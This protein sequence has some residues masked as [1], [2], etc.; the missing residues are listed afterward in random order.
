MK[1]YFKVVWECGNNETDYCYYQSTSISA[2][3]SYLADYGFSV[4]FITQ[5]KRVSRLPKRAIALKSYYD[6]DE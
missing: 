2:L 4:G 5:V 3:L 1:Y 6:K